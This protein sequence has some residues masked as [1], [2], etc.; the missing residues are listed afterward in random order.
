MTDVFP[1]VLMSAAYILLF[2]IPIANYESNRSLSVLKRIQKINYDRQSTVLVSSSSNR[3][4]NTKTL[5]FGDY[6]NS[7][8]EKEY[9][10]KIFDNV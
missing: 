8:V 1:N 9:I 2:T 6:I 7:F 4:G 3:V 10:K 5:N